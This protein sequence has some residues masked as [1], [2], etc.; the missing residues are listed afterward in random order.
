M[1]MAPAP[2]VTA[3]TFVLGEKTGMDADRAEKEIKEQVEQ[4]HRRFV[5]QA[6]N[7]ME[8]GRGKPTSG[9]PGL[10][11]A[12]AGIS[13]VGSCS[14]FYYSNEE[15]RQVRIVGIG[16]HVGGAAYRLTYAAEGLGGSGRILRIA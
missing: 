1:S 15:T 12:S 2:A 11:H 7:D 5:S 8:F 14:V 4:A 6:V 10:W 3:P 9:Y 13:G 16:H